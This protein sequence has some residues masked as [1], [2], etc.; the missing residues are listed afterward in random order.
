MILNDYFPTNQKLLFLI[1]PITQLTFS[2]CFFK[3]NRYMEVLKN[4]LIT[5]FTTTVSVLS[6]LLMLD[7]IK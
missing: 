5:N 6:K 1:I 3:S 2:N 7:I 4:I